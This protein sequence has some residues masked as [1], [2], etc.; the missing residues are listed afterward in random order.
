MVTC[1][2]G[3]TIIELM[4]VISIIGVLALT[5]VPLT[6]GWLNDT[7]INNA[8]SQLLRGYS[9]AKAQ[10]LRNAANATGNT[11]AACLTITATQLQV[12]TPVS[13]SC[14]GAVQWQ[15]EWPSGVALTINNATVTAIFMNNRGQA[16]L[17]N[18]PASTDLAYRLSKGNRDDAGQLR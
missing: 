15:G 1:R 3:F 17:N 4:V 8:R 18:V 13:G 10:A 5:A 12:R 16:L 2:R 11:A 14:T 6:Q 7:H 9:Q